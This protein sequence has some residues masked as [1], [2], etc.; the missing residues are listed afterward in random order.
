MSDVLPA[1]TEHHFESAGRAVG[2]SPRPNYDRA[3][4]MQIIGAHHKTI[5]SSE[6]A[7]YEI[8]PT[9]I[10]GIILNCHKTRILSGDAA[11]IDFAILVAQHWL[12]NTPYAFEW[13]PLVTFEI[14]QILQDVPRRVEDDD[15]DQEASL[16]LHRVISQAL[17]DSDAVRLEKELESLYAETADG[18]LDVLEVQGFIAISMTNP[19][20]DLRRL[21][22]Q[23]RTIAAVA[24]EFGIQCFQPIV[25]NNPLTDRAAANSPMAHGIDEHKLRQTD[26]TFI[27]ADPAAS[28]IGSVSEMARRFGS[29]RVVFT[30]VVPVSPMITGARP[31]PA[32]IELG[33]NAE[34]NL[35]D[36]LRA[37]IDRI[38]ARRDRRLLR[39]ER[40]QRWHAR[41][42]RSLKAM[43]PDE[44]ALNWSPV[45][46]EADRFHAV[47]ADASRVT[48]LTWAET[49]SLHQFVAAAEKA[50]QL[51]IDE[52]RAV[53][54]AER[55][56]HWVPEDTDAIVRAALDSLRDSMPVDQAFTFHRSTWNDPAAWVSFHESRS[57]QR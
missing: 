45:D 49:L 43:T 40:A 44:L 31:E 33:P 56:G 18:D 27:V 6:R 22:E 26:V 46:I 53:F 55:L 36:Y 50:P 25:V 38:K 10:F 12:L 15:L 52:Q 41:L 24:K 42:V 37:N 30:G 4:S 5:E 3:A 35:R 13:S 21:I 7:P 28:G 14:E 1:L 16:R 32:T 9:A 48:E 57:R 34:Q 29:L 11:T 17:A 39:A 8:V 2:P 47:I 23:S 54:D 51:T 19:N 20:Q